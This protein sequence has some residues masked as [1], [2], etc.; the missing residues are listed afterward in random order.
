MTTDLD[1][2]PLSVIGSLTQ[3]TPP[4]RVLDLGCGEGRHALHFARNGFDV[5]AVDHDADA[6][7]RLELRA[8][9][10][11]LDARLTLIH[12]EATSFLRANETW[13][14]VILSLF[15]HEL[16]H[17]L[18]S[19]VVQRAQGLTNPKGWNA[20]A[21]WLDEGEFAKRVPRGSVR[22]FLP[23]YESL[24]KRYADW[25]KVIGGFEGAWGHPDPQSREVFQGMVFSQL[26]QRT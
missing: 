1:S 11:H 25:H 22:P 8:R 17:A 18:G 13:D 5:T 15:L 24:M 19:L 14:I 12:Q 2:E 21:L 10:E 6:L 7:D 9:R 23:D 4:C 26:F 3:L 16:P 20:V